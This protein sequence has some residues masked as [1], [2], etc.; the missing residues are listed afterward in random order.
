QP[1]EADAETGA[2]IIDALVV[3]GETGIRDMVDK[4][5]D[6]PDG[7]DPVAQ[8]EGFAKQQMRAEIF[9]VGLVADDLAVI[10]AATEEDA[11]GDA[12]ARLEDVA[13]KL[14]G[15]GGAEVKLVGVVRGV[16]L[17]TEGGAG[18]NRPAQ[19]RCRRG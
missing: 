3:P 13:A 19:I 9:A 2:H 12:V 4:R 14:P 8:F 5:R 15:P 7:I 18:L 16:G 6:L 1:S 17:D 10:Q 11:A